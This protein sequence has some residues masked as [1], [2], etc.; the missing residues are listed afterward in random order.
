[1]PKQR[2]SVS[3]EALDL[4]SWCSD[5][6]CTQR[7]RRER[8]ARQMLS[9]LPRERWVSS[10]RPRLICFS[11]LA[12][13]S[14]LGKRSLPKR[15]TGLLRSETGRTFSLDSPAPWQKCRHIAGHRPAYEAQGVSHLGLMFFLT[16]EQLS[17]RIIEGCE[18]NATEV[19]RIALNWG[20]HRDLVIKAFDS[21]RWLKCPIHFAR[22]VLADWRPRSRSNIGL[23]R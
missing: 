1:M 13:L 3:E 16:K 11:S 12:C 9:V 17:R 7:F 23:M 2:S 19:L 4:C 21:D 6:P 8:A 22:L 14:G 18:R 10:K 20:K 5:C 15:E